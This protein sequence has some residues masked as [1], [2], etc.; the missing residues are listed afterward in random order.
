MHKAQAWWEHHRKDDGEN[1]NLD[2]LLNFSRGQKESPE[3]LSSGTADS[4]LCERVRL[5]VLYC[6]EKL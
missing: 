2:E 3:E 5:S 4:D 1:C 6:L